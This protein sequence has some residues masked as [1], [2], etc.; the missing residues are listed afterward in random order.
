[1]A[2]ASE[3]T[4]VDRIIKA[5]KN[6]TLLAWVVV[7]FVAVVAVADLLGALDTIRHAMHRTPNRQSIGCRY[8][9]IPPLGSILSGDFE[10]DQPNFANVYLADTEPIHYRSQSE[11]NNGSAI[12]LKN[13]EAGRLAVELS[14]AP[15]I[16]TPVPIGPPTSW[17]GEV[18]LGDDMFL[19]INISDSDHTTLQ[20]RVTVGP[21]TNNSARQFLARHSILLPDC[22]S[23]PTGIFPV[24]SSANH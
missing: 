4:R 5:V 22:D 3:D 8:L 12:V 14:V 16:S 23:V 10:R 1:L 18:T 15:R 21:T 20:N 7:A 24:R 19:I 6:H 13:L 2:N 9:L 11:L 17:A